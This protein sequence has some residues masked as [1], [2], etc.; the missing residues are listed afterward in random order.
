MSDDTGTRRLNETRED[1]AGADDP[2]SPKAETLSDDRPRSDPRRV[3][4]PSAPSLFWPIMLIG[5]GLVLLLAQTGVI[6]QLDWWALLRLWPVL[7]ILA[8]VDVLFS[9]RAPL[10]GGL[11]GLGVVA[12]V[13]LSA[14][15]GSTERNQR[16]DHPTFFD[17]LA[18]RTA[19]QHTSLAE[20][21]GDAESLRL[22][23]DA[24][25]FP[26]EIS[27]LDDSGNLLEAEVDHVGRLRFDATGGHARRIVMREEYRSFRWA[28]GFGFA[29]ERS[30]DIGINP[31]VSLD[32]SVDGGSGSVSLDLVG[33]ELANL[34]LDVGSGS[35]SADLPM[36]Q[37]SVRHDG[38]SGSTRFHVGSG[39]DVSMRADTSSGST[40]VRVEE[41]ATMDLLLTDAGSGSIS[42]SV[43]DGYPLRVDLRDHGSGSVRLPRGMDKVK[44]G[45]DD[46]EG[47]WELGDLG[48]AEDKVL[49]RVDDMGSGSLNVSYR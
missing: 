35:L 33:L 6:R 10:V 40:E 44:R 47:V 46:K 16:Q 20:P 27:A 14:S 45:G 23:V 22:R 43:P 17:K 13:L 37:Y 1:A 32:M 9:R 34:E 36:G 49:I 2:A 26:V 28:T 4:R 31:D 21:L 41:G 39:A 42:V 38:G 25:Q 7:L 48:S 19:V 5:A 24:G 11:L 8:G 15:L 30:W 29:E 3:S 18:G 12:L